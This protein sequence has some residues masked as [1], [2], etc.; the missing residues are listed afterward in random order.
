[1]SKRILHNTGFALL[2]LSALT[3]VIFQLWNR[4]IVSFGTPHVVS[5]NRSEHV[6]M[7]VTSVDTVIHWKTII[8]L[9][10]ASA[11]GLACLVIADKRPKNEA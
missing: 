9:S 8:P 11:I 3:A 7:I 10:A 2:T 6:M 4:S 1:M 5:E